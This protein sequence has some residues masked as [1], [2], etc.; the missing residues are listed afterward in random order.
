M[1]WLSVITKQ[2]INNMLE[3]VEKPELLLKLSEQT[4]LTSC[5]P[6][7]AFFK[8]QSVKNYVRMLQDIWT[9][10]RNK[11]IFKPFDDELRQFFSPGFSFESD[12]ES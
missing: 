12:F 7:H 10:L 11:R 2:N 3:L 4:N 6:E 5:I 9:K 8:E 1:A